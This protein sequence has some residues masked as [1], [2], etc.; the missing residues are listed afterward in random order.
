LPDPALTATQ[1]S[2]EIPVKHFSRVLACTDFSEP[3]NRAIEAAMDVLDEDTTLLLTHVLETLPVPNPMYAHYSPSEWDQDTVSKAEAEARRALQAL[4][5]KKKAG[6]RVEL[7]V[8]HGRTVHEILRIA[9]EHGIDLILVGTH[10]RSGLEHLL[11]GSVAERVVRHA[12]CSVLM[13]R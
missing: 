12:K 7:M 1:L 10:G 9:E 6:A 4:V 8:G 11:L 5:P 13:V 2:K 3:G